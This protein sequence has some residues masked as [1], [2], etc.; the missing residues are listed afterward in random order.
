[1]GQALLTGSIAYGSIVRLEVLH[2]RPD[3]IEVELPSVLNRAFLELGLDAARAGRPALEIVRGAPRTL[4]VDDVR[5]AHSEKDPAWKGQFVEV[6][7]AE[8]TPYRRLGACGCVD[9]V[10]ADRGEPMTPIA[11]VNVGL[12]M[13]VYPQVSR[14]ETSRIRQIDRRLPHWLICGTSDPRPDQ[15]PHHHLETGNLVMC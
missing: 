15:L 8:S 14:G 6:H 11:K 13:R 12:D 3:A 2:P 7:V 4:L 10:D 9:V 1:M 5:A